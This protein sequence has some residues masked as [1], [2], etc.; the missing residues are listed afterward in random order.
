M[1]TRIIY[2]LCQ[3][4]GSRLAR[5][6]SR[7]RI[8]HLSGTPLLFSSLLSLLTDHANHRE[9]RA[10][11]ATR[12]DATQLPLRKL[13]CRFWMSWAR[14]RCTAGHVRAAHVNGWVTRFCSKSP[15]RDLSITG[16]SDTPRTHFIVFVHRAPGDLNGSDIIVMRLETTLSSTSPNSTEPRLMRLISNH[17]RN[18]DV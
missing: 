8:P 15:V 16:M 9:N 3:Q 11:R 17:D 1:L 12:I 10:G 13:S 4:L 6:R 5:D 14:H 7:L 18:H 2:Y